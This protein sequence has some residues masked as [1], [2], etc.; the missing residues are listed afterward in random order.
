[1]ACARLP[2]RQA[3]GQLEPN[4]TAG[5]WFSWPRAK[6]FLSSRR[7]LLAG[8]SSSRT[9]PTA[10][11]GRP[12]LRVE[13][14]PPGAISYLRCRPSRVIPGRRLTGKLKIIAAILE[15]PVV[16]KIL[17]LV[18]LQARRLAHLPP[19]PSAVRGCATIVLTDG[20]RSRSWKSRSARWATRKVC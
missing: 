19:R 1:M 15:A 18:G 5:L 17:T 7:P 10:D 12:S 6:A 8:S 16:D 2:Y 14:Q 4:G 11:P 13:S 20:F 3:F 9:A